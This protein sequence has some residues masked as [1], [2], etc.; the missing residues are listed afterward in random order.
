MLRIHSGAARDRPE[1]NA[2]SKHPPI[3]EVVWQQH[4][5]NDTKK[6]NVNNTNKD[7]TLKTNVASQT[8][9]PK[10][11]QLQKYVDT[12]EQPPGNQTGN[13]LV[14]FLDSSKISTNT[15]NAEQHVVTTLS[16]D[17]TASP[18]TTATPLI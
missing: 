11:T 6:H 14:P 1:I 8:S 5:E 18:L 15:Q 7:S 16:G 3:L 10:G 17:T 12:T 13:E 2:K 4:T 9:P